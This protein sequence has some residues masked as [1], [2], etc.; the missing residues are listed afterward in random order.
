MIVQLKYLV[1]LCVSLILSFFSVG[2]NEF[3]EGID[4]YNSKN[5]STA[6]EK[7]EQIIATSPNNVSAWYNLGLSN[8]GLHKYGDAIWNF[9]KVLKLAPSDSEAAEK[10]NYCYTELHNDRTWEPR[11]NSVESSLY[12]FSSTTWSIVSIGFSFVLAI[13]LIFRSKQKHRSLRNVFTIISV[14]LGLLMISSITIALN[15]QSYA[16]ASN[17]AIVTKTMIPTFIEAGKTAKSSLKEGTRVK[18]LTTSEDDFIEVLT[19]QG[20]T[21]L[22]RKNDLS[23]I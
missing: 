17:V 15:S 18:F 14:V 2:Q 5:Y 9:E 23:I 3:S 7:F 6:I 4:A 16:T 11:L 13:T 21:C 8:M 1:V 10:I 22:V 20:E 12:S 19:D